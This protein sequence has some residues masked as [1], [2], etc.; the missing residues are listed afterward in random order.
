MLSYLRQ[1]AAAAIFL[2]ISA[3]SIAFD[4]SHACESAWVKRFAIS[5][6]G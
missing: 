2:G 6:D 4:G 1:P 3:G 5:N